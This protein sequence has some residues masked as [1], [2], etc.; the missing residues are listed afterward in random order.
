[1]S[2]F[3]SPLTVCLPVCLSVLTWKQVNSEPCWREPGREEREEE[4]Q[5]ENST[6]ACILDMRRQQVCRAVRSFNPAYFT[7]EWNC[8]GK[9]G[10]EWR[11]HVLVWLAVEMETSEERL[12]HLS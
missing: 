11:R 1:M 12:Q 5:K 3:P 8:F 10:Q 6:D 9:I 2:T 7:R 4:E